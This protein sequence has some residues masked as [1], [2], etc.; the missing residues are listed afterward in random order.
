MR[1]ASLA[2]Q[3]DVES[4][5]GAPDCAGRNAEQEAEP[6]FKAGDVVGYKPG[7]IMGNSRYTIKCVK[8]QYSQGQRYDGPTAYDFTSEGEW[9][10]EDSLVLVATND[11]ALPCIVARVQD[12]QPRPS[13][14]PHVHRSAAEATKEAERLASVNPGKQF[15]VYQ[16]VT[17]RVAEQH[18]EVKVA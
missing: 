17:G 13:S 9:D 8:T 15:D 12:G 2:E 16:R 1:G 6:K 3:A 10:T 14:W 7:S 5:R 18:I 4:R 11:P